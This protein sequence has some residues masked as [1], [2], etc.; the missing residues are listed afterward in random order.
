MPNP[1]NQKVSTIRDLI[2]GSRKKNILLQ[3]K[4]LWHMFC[5]CMDT[6]GDTEIALESFLKL[7]T[8]SSDEGRNYLRIYGA[9]QA[10]YVQQD[11][12]KYLHDALKIPYSID[13]LVQNIRDIRNNATG[14]PTNRNYK[15]EFNFIS[16]VTL[17]PQSF[18]LLTFYRTNSGNC[19]LD[20]KHNNIN[21][22]DL[23][24]T[25][26][27]VFVEVLNNI[28]E[29]L[30]EEDVEHKKKFEGNTLT[31]VFK[32][33]TYAFEKIFD[34]ILSTDSPHIQFVGKYVG[35]ILESV[36]AFKTGLKER[37]EPD[38]D[39]T[40]LYENLDHALKHIKKYFHAPNETH[41]QNED[42][43]IFADFSHRQI[44]KLVETARQI[45]EEY[46]EM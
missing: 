30:Q 19:D 39:L 12:I 31:D 2:N 45:D 16:R 26:I 32:G 20:T 4:I 33:T 28:I 3:D 1:L 7:D 15:K 8:D 9:L 29:V 41:I 13:P 14:H 6:I 40:D 38:E 34:A 35:D 42:L 25:Q 46:S 22:P 27:N 37:E 5:S 10:L 43:Y 18:E 24:V 21:I 17:T 23:I 44:G 11:A 36:E